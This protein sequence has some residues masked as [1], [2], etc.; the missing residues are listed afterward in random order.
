MIG[1]LTW[2][3]AK[4]ARQASKSASLVFSLSML[5]SAPALASS[6]IADADN[7]LTSNK[8]KQAEEAYRSLLVD[9]SSGDVYAGLA[10]ALAKQSWPA[11]ILD[12]EKVLRK[13]KQNFPDNPNVMAAGGYVSFVHSKTVA[14]PAKRDQYLEASES[15][16]K[17]ATTARPDILIAQQT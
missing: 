2:H 1:K 11:K 3:L 8:Y 10:V 15:L 9:D 13:A 12:A 4:K 16:C 7:L 17:R 14:S 6:T 5:W